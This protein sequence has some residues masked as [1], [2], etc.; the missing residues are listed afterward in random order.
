MDLMLFRNIKKGMEEGK[1]TFNHLKSPT[2]ESNEY[3]VEA[4]MGNE[5]VSM[6]IPAKEYSLPYNL[7]N[8]LEKLKEMG[9]SVPY[10]FCINGLLDDKYYVHRYGMCQDIYLD[11]V[12][13]KYDEAMLVS[14]V[15]ATE[16]VNHYNFNNLGKEKTRFVSFNFKGCPIAVIEKYKTDT[17]IEEKG[18]Y[19][20]KIENLS[21]MIFDVNKKLREKYGLNVPV[22]IEFSFD[23]RRRIIFGYIINS[24]IACQKTFY[25]LKEAEEYAVELIEH[26]SDIS[27]S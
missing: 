24:K 13:K 4:T 6:Y 21:K 14:L 12:C 11:T 15:D 3:L 2:K 18:I 8:A 23:K 27:H 10:D 25:D 5:V 9:M 7:Y 1:I 26:L 22:Y 20:Y 16:Q 19:D 17:K